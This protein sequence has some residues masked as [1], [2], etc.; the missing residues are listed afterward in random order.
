MGANAAAT[1]SYFSR[2]HLVLF[3][4]SDL[5]TSP[6]LHLFAMECRSGTAACL[7]PARRPGDCCDFPFRAAERPAA[8]GILCLRLFCN[9][10]VSSTRLLRC[11]FFPLLICQRSFSV[12]GE[13]GTSRAHRSDHLAGVRAIQKSKAC[14]FQCSPA[15]V[16][17]A[18]LSSNCKVSRRD[19][20][21]SRY[22]CGKSRLLDG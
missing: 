1:N 3:A 15:R 7:S 4:E 21:L 10:V 13:H 17:S 9:H 5:A 11:L 8:S 22:A 14:F 16:S 19:H 12:F 6:H 2:C 20:S 18:D